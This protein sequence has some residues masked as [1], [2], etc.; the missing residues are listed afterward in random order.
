[1][2]FRNPSPATANP[3]SANQSG[4]SQPEGRVFMDVLKIWYYGIW[5]KP[6]RSWYVEVILVLSV[7]CFGSAGL[8]TIILLVAKT[9]ADK[10]A[11]LISLFL[12]LAVGVAFLGDVIF[13]IAVS[14]SAIK[15]F[16]K[17]FGILPPTRPELTKMFQKDIDFQ[18]SAHAN[19]CKGAFMIAK[20][21]K[22]RFEQLVSP[23]GKPP[24][25]SLGQ[26]E[27]VL[28]ALEKE[29]ESAEERI[30]INKKVFW[31]AHNVASSKYL[32]APFV[33]HK[34]IEEY[35]EIGPNGPT[36]CICKKKKRG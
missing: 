27:E 35:Y 30:K 20:D 25:F 17:I 7:I 13:Q 21:I 8:S 4:K 36:K 11:A 28:I 19:A 3:V 2:G 23:A 29:L 33:T 34:K 31:T 16:R 22:Q 6:T 5:K 32:P 14:L 24:G 15:R 10:A 12:F 1:M 18:L 26:V 9:S